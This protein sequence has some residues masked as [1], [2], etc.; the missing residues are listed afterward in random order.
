MK[1]IC[2]SM[3]QISSD[4]QKTRLSSDLTGFLF[5]IYLW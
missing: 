1:H 5:V 4:L 2:K 3:K